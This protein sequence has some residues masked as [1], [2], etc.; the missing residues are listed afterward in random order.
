M[1]ILPKWRM[2]FKEPG[3][4]FKMILYIF[5]SIAL[6]FAGIFWYNYNISRK[7]VEKNIK[8]NAENLTIATVLKVNQVLSTAQKIPDNFSKIIE[9]YDL[10]HDDYKSLLRGIIENNEDIY[11]TAL[12]FE[13]YYTSD[14]VKYYAPYFYRNDSTIT[15]KNIGNEHYDYFT[16]DWYQIPRE[17]ERPVWSEPYYDQGAGN[18]IMST[19]SVPIFK[20]V[21]GERKVIAIL[22][23][24]IELGWLNDVMGAVKIFETG[25]AFMVSGTGT[26][27]THP[28]KDIMF[29][30]TIFSISDLQKSP[31][32]REIG[33]NMIHGKTSFAEFEYFN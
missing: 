22:T 8:L 3:L 16:M 21:D 33:R 31:M 14:T 30:E 2:R 17:L 6:I 1:N 29:N 12:A 25:Y 19:Y 5:F 4:A 27:I 26:I 20:T 28:D 24:D 18:T 9:S 15:W 11:G 7:I 13:P 10:K 32:L 23:M